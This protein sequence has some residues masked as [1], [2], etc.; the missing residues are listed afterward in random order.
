MLEDEINNILIKYTNQNSTTKIKKKLFN[1]TTKIT[2]NNRKS[3]TTL[4][5]AENLTIEYLNT[6][7]SNIF[8][9]KPYTSDFNKLYDLKLVNQ[10]S[11]CLNQVDELHLNYHLGDMLI[12]PSTNANLTIMDFMSRDIAKLY[13]TSEKVGNV[14]KIAQ[15]PRKLLGIFKNKVVIFL[16]QEFKG[17]LTVN[18]LTGNTTF[19][20]LQQQFM[21]DATNK[22]GSVLFYQL[23]VD[24]L[25]A[26]L[27][28]GNIGLIDSYAQDM[29]INTK[30]GNIFAKYILTDKP[31]SIISLS[32]ISGNIIL[33]NIKA[34]NL[35]IHT[36]SGNLKGKRLF[37]QNIDAS[38]DAGNIN[39]KEV[40]GDGNISSQIG[41]IKVTLFSTF[42]SK[43][44]IK[45]KV[46]NIKVVI[47]NNFN[48]NFSTKAHVGT[49][50]LPFDAIINTDNE[51]EKMS[52]Y[53][54]TVD[55]SAMIELE[56]DLGNINLIKSK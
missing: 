15:G 23:K 11:I 10:L 49:I 20:N 34:P 21:L 35:L 24:R 51:Y 27:N 26:D 5:A 48:Y 38:T 46:G 16:P 12:L 25:Q 28:E 41:N 30:S 3:E 50:H 42:E 56:N 17:F 44:S 33:R 1:L 45:S 37:Q 54:G 9:S 14:V 40:L 22:S 47:P 18:N 31:N 39:L 32:T 55:T 4:N 52:G 2:D 53:V 7:G 8:S 36:K 6:L 13:S 19:M 29:H 43:L